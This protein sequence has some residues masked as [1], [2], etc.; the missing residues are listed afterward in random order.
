[1]EIEVKK[2]VKVNIMNIYMKVKDTFYC[3]IRTEDNKYV[4]EYEGYV[5]HFFPEEHYGDYLDLKIDMETGQIL[6]W[7]KPIDDDLNHLIEE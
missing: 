1:M 5:P 2:K 3:T 7:V 6:N 4:A